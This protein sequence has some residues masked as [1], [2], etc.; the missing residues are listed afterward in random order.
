VNIVRYVVVGVFDDVFVVAVLCYC[1][2]LLIDVT[3]P[4]ILMHCCC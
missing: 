4:V 1:L 2:L 3:V